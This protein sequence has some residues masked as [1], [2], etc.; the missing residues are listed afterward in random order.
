MFNQEKKVKMIF[1]KT[2]LESMIY[3][4]TYKV[5]SIQKGISLPELLFIELYNY[6]KTNNVHL[7]LKKKK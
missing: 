2:Q 6:L 3:T 1:R 5:Q 4:H 7:N